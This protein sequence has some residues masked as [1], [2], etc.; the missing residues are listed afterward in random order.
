M[1]EN[2]YYLFENGKQVHHSGSFE[3][4]LNFTCETTNGMI[5]YNN[6]LIWVQ[7]I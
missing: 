5:Y 6:V 2:T 3:K 7:N 4:I 1:K